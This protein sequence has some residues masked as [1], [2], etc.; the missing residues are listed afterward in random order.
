VS[1]SVFSVPGR[2]EV[3]GK[4]TDYAGGRSL[5]AAVPRVITMSAL[6][7]GDGR[8]VIRDACRGVE[9]Q[10][11]VRGE[12]PEAGWARYPRT[13]VRRLAENF[14]RANLSARLTFTSDLPQAAGMSSSSALIVAVAEA[15]IARARIEECAEW[16]ALVRTPE[17]RAAYFG[18]VENGSAFGPLTG[19]GG[20]GTHG[21]SE[22]H[23]AIVTSRAGELRQFSFS[24]LRLERSVPMPPRWTFVVACSGVSAEKTGAANA[25]YNR[26]AA[27]ALAIVEAWRA[28]H[29][30]DARSLA[31]LVRAGEV[32]TLELTPELRNRLDHFIAENERVAAASD[33]FAREDVATVGELAR[34]SQADADRR[35]GNQIPPTRD[36]ASLAYDI[37]AAAASAFGAGWGGSVWALVPT[38]DAERFLAE[39]LRAYRQKY[40]DLIPDGFVAPPSAGVRRL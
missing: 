30:G 8:V 13:V 23:A 34:A 15:L 4:H 38:D 19:D 3:F 40:P 16:Q 10:F 29:R 36:L 31:E 1:R 35:L 11:S 24:P 12:G 9:A 33:A 2:I 7:A 32:Q 21:G 18:C 22:D 37:G 25:D 26:L 14:P 39:W 17:D 28:H 27:E 5:V 20:V 6:S